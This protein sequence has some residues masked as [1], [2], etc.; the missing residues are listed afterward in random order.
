MCTYVVSRD[1]CTPRSACFKLRPAQG[2]IE[3]RPN[4]ISREYIFIYMFAKESIYTLKLARRGV[5]L[6]AGKE[7]NVPK[8]IRVRDVMNSELETVPENL[9]LGKLADRISKSKYKTFPVVAGGNHLSGMLS[10]FDYRDVIF[11]ENLRDL[12]VAQDLAT[13]QVVTVSLDSDLYDALQKI[14][15]K[16]FSLLPVVSPDDMGMRTSCLANATASAKR[17]HWS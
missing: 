13:E 10:Y 16:D 15:L 2:V 7:V 4:S 11:D 5:N 9:S 17:P 3:F 1:T 14:T 8:S 6:E 12:L